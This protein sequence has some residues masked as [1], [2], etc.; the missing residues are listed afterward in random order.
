MTRVHCNLA[1]FDLDGT[2][3]K[4]RRRR[5]VDAVGRLCQ[6][7]RYQVTR[8]Q[9]HILFSTENM[10]GF[11]ARSDQSW[12]A[13]VFWDSYAPREHS[14]VPMP[15][16]AGALTY[17]QRLGVRTAVATARQC[18]DT[19]VRSALLTAKLSHLIDDVIGAGVDERLDKPAMMRVLCQRAGC[20]SD[21]AMAVGDTTAD[22]R[23]ARDAGIGAVIA[24]CSGQIQR[25]VLQGGK[26][27]MV[28]RSVAEI[29]GYVTNDRY[30][31]FSSNH[32]FSCPRG[33]EEQWASYTD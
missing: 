29:P 21:A 3:I 4:L 10:F 32:K 8:R 15:G 1:I 9:L 13:M 17:L 28:L 20:G 24:V 12:L 23:A 7:Y 26:P 2:L 33:D 18:S 31:V 14:A 19:D 11:A 30:A 5:F 22:V 16:A 27:D 25:P 6:D